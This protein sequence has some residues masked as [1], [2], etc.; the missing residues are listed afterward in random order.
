M[1][2]SRNLIQRR[3]HTVLRNSCSSGQARMHS[4]PVDRRRGY[5]RTRIPRPHSIPARTLPALAP[6]PIA[7]SLPKTGASP[8]RAIPRPRSRLRRNRMRRGI[9]PPPPCRSRHHSHHWLPCR[10]I[11]RKVPP[12]RRSNRASAPRR[13]PAANCAQRHRCLPRNLL[14][15]KRTSSHTGRR[16]SAPNRNDRVHAQPITRMHAHRSTRNWRQRPLVS[17]R[18]ARQIDPVPTRPTVPEVART[19][20]PPKARPVV[21]ASTPKRRPPPPVPRTPHIP[22]PGRVHPAAIPIRIKPAHARVERLPHRSLPR[23]V[24]RPIR[25][26][27]RPSIPLVPGKPIP[28]R[29]PYRCIIRRRLLP[30]LI[31]VVPRIALDLRRQKIARAP[32]RIAPQRLALAHVHAIPHPLHSRML[33][34]RRPIQ[35]RDLRWRLVQRNPNGR[36][37]HRRHRVFPGIDPVRI[38]RGSPQ[39]R[40][41]QPIHHRELRVKVAIRRRSEP[42]QHHR[43]L[44]CNT[45]QAPVLELNLRLSIPARR[46]ANSLGQRHIQLSRIASRVVRMQNRHIAFEVSQPHC[47]DRRIIRRPREV[48]P[49]AHHGEKKH[50]KNAGTT[51][52]PRPQDRRSSPQL[53]HHPSPAAS[54][55][56]SLRHCHKD[57]T[58][59]KANAL[60]LPCL[61]P[62]PSP[63]PLPC[64]RP[65]PCCCLCSC[66]CRCPCCCLCSCLCPSVC[67][68]RRESAVAFCPCCCLC[69]CLCLCRC[70]SVCHSRR[71]SAVASC[72]CPRPCPSVCHSRRESA[73]ALP[74]PVT[75][76]RARQPRIAYLPSSARSS[77][78][79]ARDRTLCIRSLSFAN[80]RNSGAIV[81][82]STALP[83][84]FACVSM[85]SSASSPSRS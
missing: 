59:P 51:A 35:N 65:C 7:P 36:V 78:F 24:P 53:P 27:I 52:S 67:H 81:P 55:G 66:L 46:D 76:I 50:N 68:F 15:L 34:A 20:S 19:P 70:P 12:Q 26:Q 16:R 13:I 64:L 5:R 32:R 48:C 29:R 3:R 10:P 25:I 69:P 44:R 31:P 21:P 39:L 1:Q 47:P 82:S 42:R 56:S 60:L 63:S 72:P 28:S 8:P 74:L 41:H 43:T 17:R 23:V 38:L 58:Q 18:H 2:R 11:H 83:A 40:I 37:R 33:H 30:L 54:C 80:S 62:C 61:R 45:N 14:R 22:H 9:R 84:T 73:V 77:S 85:S 6:K 75:E 79:P 71:E 4:H 57:K 49:H